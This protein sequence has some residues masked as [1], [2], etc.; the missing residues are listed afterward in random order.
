[1]PNS[2]PCRP[3]NPIRVLVRDLLEAIG[4]KFMWMDQWRWMDSAPGG[5]QGHVDGGNGEFA[6]VS[7]DRMR[8]AAQP[9]ERTDAS[10]SVCNDDAGA[11]PLRSGRHRAHESV[12]AHLR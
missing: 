9:D 12:G 5:W 10:L 1:M 11:D 8:R 4:W 7:G 6:W 3:E 2:G